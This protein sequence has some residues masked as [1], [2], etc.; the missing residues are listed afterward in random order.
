[1]KHL[2]NIT[3]I[4]VGTV[5]PNLIQV[6]PPLEEK[7][8]TLNKYNMN[9][10]EGSYNINLIRHYLFWRIYNTYLNLLINS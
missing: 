6:D 4:V 2:T 5:T 7:Y 8:E 1:M 10:S 3:W 9:S